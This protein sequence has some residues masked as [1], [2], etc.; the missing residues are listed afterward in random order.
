[1]ETHLLPHRRIR[2]EQLTCQ[3]LRDHRHRQAALKGLLAEGLPLHEAE[4]IDPPVVRIDFLHRHRQLRRPIGRLHE[5]LMI[6]AMI[7]GHS[8]HLLDPFIGSFEQGI[9]Q[10]RAAYAIPV[11][12]LIDAIFPDQLPPPVHIRIERGKFH[13]EHDAQH[14][15]QGDRQSRPDNIDRAEQPLLLD[16]SPSLLHI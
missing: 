6:E 12:F 11:R 1:M 13:V 5:I 15:H 8:L 2:T 7:Y 3:P 14:H 16:Q 10:R 9:R 4:G